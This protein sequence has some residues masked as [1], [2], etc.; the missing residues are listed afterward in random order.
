MSEMPTHEEMYE[1]KCN[2]FVILKHYQDGVYCRGFCRTREKA[3]E[4]VEKHGDKFSGH[5]VE[6]HIL[7]QW[8]SGGMVSHPTVGP[9]IENKES[10][11]M[12]DTRIKLP[13]GMVYVA[14]VEFARRRAANL[15]TGVASNALRYAIE[16]AL[17]WKKEHPTVPTD[18]QLIAVSRRPI[19][20]THGDMESMRATIVE[21]QRREYDSPEP[22]NIEDLLL[23]NI[24]SGFFKPEILNE[25]LHE[26]FRRGRKQGRSERSKIHS[27][28]QAGASRL[29]SCLYRQG[30]VGS[31]RPGYHHQRQQRP[32]D[33]SRRSYARG[34]TSDSGCKHAATD[35]REARP[36]KH[37]TGLLFPKAA[38]CLEEENGDGGAS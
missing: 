30:Q 29:V 20:A 7:D 10:G 34:D 36:G 27:V 26:A 11:R 16:A 8:F 23:P 17:Q 14:G 32:E 25:R 35:G 28:L 38:V 21:W 33:L 18:E 12:S 4:L 6:G 2:L 5:T 19:G 3:N 13:E 31:T 22:I 1:Q 37:R 15:N 24:E 9:S